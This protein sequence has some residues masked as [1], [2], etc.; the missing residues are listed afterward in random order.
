M[1]LILS[2]VHLWS[3][4]PIISSKI[5]PFNCDIIRNYV[6]KFRK[7]VKLIQNFYRLTKNYVKK[8]LAVWV[9]LSGFLEKTNFL[10]KISLNWKSNFHKMAMIV[11]NRFIRLFSFPPFL[12]KR[13]KKKKYIF[14]PKRCTKMSQNV[15]KSLGKGRKLSVC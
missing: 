7:I 9:Q 6:S 10:R 8:F 2:M 14:F 11:I 4:E 15:S 5:T 13:N 3:I 1:R 12:R